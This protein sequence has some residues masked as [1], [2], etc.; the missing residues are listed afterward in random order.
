MGSFLGGG[1]GQQSGAGQVGSAVGGIAGNL[2]LPGVGGA[3]GSALGGVIGGAIGGQSQKKMEQ[4]EEIVFRGTPLERISL[5]TWVLLR[6][7]NLYKDNSLDL[8]RMVVS[9]NI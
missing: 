7:N 2:L 1:G 3:I 6:Y 8:W 4:I 9:L 5:V